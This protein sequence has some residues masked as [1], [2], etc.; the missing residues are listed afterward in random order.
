MAAKDVIVTAPRFGDGNWRGGWWAMY[1]RATGRCI[2]K[3]KHR[4]GAELFDRS[5]DV[6]FCNDAQVQWGLCNLTT[7][8]RTPL[9]ATG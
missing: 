4:R 5:G 3:R 8:R 7:L 1:E 6:I 2:W 9:V